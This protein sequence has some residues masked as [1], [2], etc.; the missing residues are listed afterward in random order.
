[1]PREI[2]SILAALVAVFRERVRQ[3]RLWGRQEHELI[4]P[5]DKT[6]DEE[7]EAYDDKAWL[8]KELCNRRAEERK[9]DWRTIL[10]EEVYELLA[11]DKLDR[12]IAEAVQ[13]SAVAAEIAERLKRKRREP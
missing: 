8:F 13:V 5:I 6:L 2:F 1:M 7:R 3:Y 11:E 10:F 4:V 12:Q 9:D